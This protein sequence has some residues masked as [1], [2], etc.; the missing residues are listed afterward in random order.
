MKGSTHIAVAASLTMPALRRARELLKLN[1]STVAAPDSEAGPKSSLDQSAIKRA[2]IAA[3]IDDGIELAFADL[4]FKAYDIVSKIG[5]LALLA[6]P[7][8]GT[9]ALLSGGFS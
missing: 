6:G 2:Y 5:G 8:L 3:Q 4:E 7:C 9:L 1:R